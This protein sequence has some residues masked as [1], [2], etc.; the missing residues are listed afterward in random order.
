ML[1]LR[2]RF[3]EVHQRC[4]NRQRQD[5]SSHRGRRRPPLWRITTAINCPPGKYRTG[6]TARVSNPADS[7]EREAEVSSRYLRQSRGYRRRRQCGGV[8]AY[9]HLRCQADPSGP[10][11]GVDH[12]LRTHSNRNAVTV[13]CPTKWNQKPQSTPKL[14]AGHRTRSVEVAAIATIGA[15]SGGNETWFRL[16]PNPRDRW[17]VCGSGKI[18]TRRRGTRGEVSGVD[19]EIS[20]SIRR[21]QWAAWQ[22]ALAAI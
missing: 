5:Q 9:R 1:R 22:P 16:G 20:T 15:I 12:N 18:N 6:F 13:E 4:G 3:R 8:N 2:I 14:G 17:P 19:G 11:T 7:R 10:A 21:A